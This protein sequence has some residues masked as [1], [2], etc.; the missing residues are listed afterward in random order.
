MATN[1]AAVTITYAII[2]IALHTFRKHI[3]RLKLPSSL[4]WAGVRKGLF[5]RERAHLQELFHGKEFLA[6]GYFKVQSNDTLS[7]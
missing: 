6:E 4:P 3:R 7:C 2:V 1:L 5:A